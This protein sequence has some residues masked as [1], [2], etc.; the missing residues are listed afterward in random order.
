MRPRYAVRPYAA[1]DAAKLQLV[2]QPLLER[3][4]W[5][6]DEPP[7]SQSAVTLTRDGSPIG[8]GGLVG[9]DERTAYAWSWLMPLR[10]SE[11]GVVLGFVR[12]AMRGLALSETGEPIRLQAS[13]GSAPAERLLRKLGFLRISDPDADGYTLF[14]WSI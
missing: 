2:G 13:A 7:S 12:Q 3:A 14:E 11:W 8:V 6:S 4:Y 1:G 5:P 9:I 10:R